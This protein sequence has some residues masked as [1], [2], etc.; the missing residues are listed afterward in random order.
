[1]EQLT[2]FLL[3]ATRM[4]FLYFLRGGTVSKHIATTKSI[5]TAIDTITSVLIVTI[6]ANIYL[7]NT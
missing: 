1:M 6:S 3:G 4:L 5:D 7:S 2:D